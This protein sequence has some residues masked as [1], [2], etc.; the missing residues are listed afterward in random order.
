MYLATGH[1]SH[2][3]PFLVSIVYCCV[4]AGSFFRSLVAFLVT[5]KT[6]QRADFDRYQFA[7]FA[8]LISQPHQSFA[9]ALYVAG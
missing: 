2:T 8:L 1:R 3:P 5:S 6:K 4:Y 7:H 9:E